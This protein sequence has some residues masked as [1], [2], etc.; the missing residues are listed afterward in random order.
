MKKNDFK[1]IKTLSLKVLSEK[2][3]QAKKDVA[4]LILDKNT[5][6]LKDV[7]VIFKKRKEIAKMMTI[8][9]QKQLV[10]EIEK[11]VSEKWLVG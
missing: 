6:K 10:E 8:L 5:K 7:K 3:K 2:I 4:D 9:N 11:E 1:E